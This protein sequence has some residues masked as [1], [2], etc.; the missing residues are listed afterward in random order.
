LRGSGQFGF[1]VRLSTLTVTING[2]K[3]GE[4]NSASLAKALIKTY[5]DE[6][7]VSKDAKTRIGEGL[8]SIIKGH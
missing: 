7:A 2:K 3:Q 5:V 8:L 6:N 4:I 1:G